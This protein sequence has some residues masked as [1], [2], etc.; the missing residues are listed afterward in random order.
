MINDQNKKSYAKGSLFIGNKQIAQDPIQLEA[1][2]IH[3]VLTL[4][5]TSGGTYTFTQIYAHR[6]EEMKD[7]LTEDLS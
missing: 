7:S 5:P 1:M 4:D 6:V 2:R 3:A